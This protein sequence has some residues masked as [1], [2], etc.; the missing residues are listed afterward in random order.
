MCGN[1]HCRSQCLL[2]DWLTILDGETPQLMSLQR[3]HMVI[4]C[5]LRKTMISCGAFP[6]HGLDPHRICNNHST[7]MLAPVASGQATGQK[8]KFHRHPWLLKDETTFHKALKLNKCR[9]QQNWIRS[10]FKK[11]NSNCDFKT[12][13]DVHPVS[14]IVMCC[15]QQKTIIVG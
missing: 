5:L 2:W 1:W 4:P 6:R 12:T 14:A 3:S 10:N 11:K 13:S 8:P 15:D 7:T 9:Q